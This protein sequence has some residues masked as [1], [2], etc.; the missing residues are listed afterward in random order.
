MSSTRTVAL[1]TP[2]ALQNSVSRL[3]LIAALTLCTA[4]QASHVAYAAAVYTYT[5]SNSGTDLWSGATHWSSLPVSATNTELTFVGNNSTHLSNGLANTNTDDING[6]ILV[7][8]SGPP[9]DRPNGSNTPAV[10]NVNSSGSNNYLNFVNNALTAPVVNLNA[11]AG[12]SSLTYN[13][14]SNIT[15]ANDT[16]FQGSGSAIFNFNGI[17][18][19]GGAL[20]KAGAST[21]TLT[22]ANT[23]S[24]AT[25]INGGTLQLSGGSDRLPTA[26]TVT[27]ANAACATLDLN[28][29]NQTIGS[30]TGGGT[31]GGNITLGSG[32]L[33]VGSSVL[34]YDYAG[35]ISGSGNLV[36]QGSGTLYLSGVNTYGGTT[37]ING[38]NLQIDG[39]IG[40][41]NY[42]PA[43]T[44]VTLA[45]VSGAMLT[46]NN[47]QQTIASLSGGGA[48]GGN[49]VAGFAGTT[50]KVG[51]ANNTTYGGS[52]TGG[53][54]V[55]QGTGTLT[56]SGVNYNT[57]TTINAGTLQLSGGSNRLSIGST[58]SMANVAGATFDLNNQNQTIDTLGGGGANGGNIT[59]G[60]GTLTVA[61]G[62]YSGV[63]S[64][65]GNLVK[66][67]SNDTLT[68]YGANTYTGATT[69]NNG[70]LQLA[71]DNCLSPVTAVTL[72]NSSGA[73]LGI[74][75][76]QTI[77]SLSG[78]GTSGGNVAFGL[79]GTTLTVGDANNT[80]YGGV[81]S[82]GANGGNGANVVK[83]G[84]GTLTLSGVNTYWG[85]TT[86]N[87]GTLQI[88]GGNNRLPTA[89]ALSLANVAGATFDVN[90]RNQTVASINGGG[91]SG[92]NITLGSGTLT[93]ANGGSFA[94]VISGTGGN[95]IK[96]NTLL[97]LVL[98]GANTYTGSTTI[99]G[100]TLQLS[101]GSD[102]LPIATRVVFD[103]GNLATLDLNG[104]NQTI[105]SISG[106]N[107]GSTIALGSGTL[108]VG[109][110]TSTTY[111]GVISGSG[112]LIK[113]GTGTLILSNG[114]GL[115]NATINAGTLRFAPSNTSVTM[116]NVA[117]ATLDF[118]NA[119]GQ[120]SR[121]SGGGPLGGN[122]TLGSG[123][124]VVGDATD[125]TYGGVISGT[126]YRTVQKVGTGKLT[127][128]GANTY[129]GITDVT[130]G[131]LQLG[132]GTTN[133][134][135][136]GDIDDD[137]S[138]IFNTAG[139][140]TYSNR[141]G[142]SGAVTKTGPGKLI[143]TGLNSP[144]SS[145]TINAGTLAMGVNNTLWTAT[146]VI[147]GGGTLA[148]GN[149]SQINA[150][151]ALTLTDDSTIDMGSV[152]SSIL[153]CADSHLA[154]WSGMLTITNWNGSL[155]GGGADELFFGSSALGL[156]PSQLS[157][158][159]FVDPNG[160]QGSYQAEILATGEVV[161]TPEPTTFAML[162]TG[163]LL[164]GAFRL[165]R[166]RRHGPSRISAIAS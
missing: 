132:D 108:T 81:I 10:I 5:P 120:I 91:A 74:S 111:A 159:V 90:N 160:L 62:G 95:L 94:G 114:G 117:G 67:N 66:G 36:K 133:G 68:L 14:N 161:P 64:G 78:G 9:G 153:E 38:G 157:E 154:L 82:G 61:S 71:S 105:A 33:T 69:I 139:I 143:L 144:V 72:A 113:Q 11:G 121:L 125:S 122:I 28:N 46:I 54:L 147:L 63:I 32:T 12:T 151:G 85:T 2:R 109:D 110:G 4:W 21:L 57:T 166:W 100:G 39:A 8:H 141:F 156:T 84:T 6:D 162:A 19:G 47:D 76:H 137:A 20:I 59:L 24:G 88:S 127:L 87:A 31:S 129:T 18:S 102:R 73:S 136:N 77:G 140:Q 99:N 163:G 22:G 75:G 89:T 29:Q 86:I 34:W 48:L 128:T 52:I 148:T 130:S 56:L 50:L 106:S 96:Q 3:L 26:T 152:G 150:L 13:V 44:A 60:S 41:L 103:S 55:K 1:E 135:V 17:I 164:L 116:A 70:T 146:P 101:G 53:L 92:G 51:D 43:T 7:E 40:S 79:S 134:S 98:S 124:L 123:F 138:L 80:T 93:V 27:L 149:F 25:T 45:N 112:T 131:T 142:G 158:I 83:Q 30:L 165:R 49:V 119:N 115:S 155:S 35:V 104:Q 65:S 97:T 37:T 118:N 42:L 107:V 145:M 23:Y 126:Y 16:T 58:I 15:L